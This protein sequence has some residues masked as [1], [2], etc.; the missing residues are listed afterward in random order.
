MPELHIA[1]LV[2]GDLRQIGERLVRS[3]GFLLAFSHAE[4]LVV[5]ALQT[6]R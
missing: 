6:E 4:D 1:L 2:D 5:E 3:R